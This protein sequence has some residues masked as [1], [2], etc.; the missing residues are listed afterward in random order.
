MKQEDK[1]SKSKSA[2][3]EWSISQSKVQVH[4]SKAKTSVKN[5]DLGDSSKQTRS[6]INDPKSNKAKHSV[7]KEN[8]KSKSKNT[9]EKSADKSS[10]KRNLP[11]SI[12]KSVEKLKG[13]NKK[14][15]V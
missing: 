12:E 6:N 10:M 4:E 5:K 11:K 2:R 15:N 13:S 8:N 9:E 3:R 7:E 14:Q 1:K